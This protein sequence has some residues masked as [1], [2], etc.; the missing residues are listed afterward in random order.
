MNPVYP[1][2]ENIKEAHTRIKSY[3]NRTPVLTSSALNEMFGIDFY[4][5]CEN[6]QKI[7]AFKYRGATNA[8][9]LLSDSEAEK[10][11]ATHSSGNHAAALSLA[12]QKRGIPAYIVM[13]KNAPEIKKIAVEGYG[14]KITFCEPTLEAREE[15]LE[16]VQKETGAAFIHPYNNFNVICGQGT[17][18]L[19]LLED[20]PFLDIVIAPVGGGGLLSGTAVTTKSVNPGIKVFAAEPLN[21]DDA[22]RSF[23]QGTI[24]PAVKPN[25]IADGLL[26]SLGS[27]TFPIIQQHVDD[28]ITAKEETIVRAMRLIWERMKIIIEPSS[29]VPLAS[30]IENISLFKGKKVGIILSGGNVDLNH[31]PF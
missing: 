31:L 26:T 18:A 23:K 2:L 28:I 1:T 29:A 9:R 16:K 21:A 25:T 15:T 30:V 7:G 5:K 17:A 13:P 12:A 27:I 11:V 22:Y 6:F 20:Y 3:I 8:V 24:A 19:E 14:A 4:F 10:G